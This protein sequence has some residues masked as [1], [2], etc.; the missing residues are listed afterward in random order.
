MFPWPKL[1]AGENLNTGPHLAPGCLSSGASLR[2]LESH[3]VAIKVSHFWNILSGSFINSLASGI[4]GGVK[5]LGLL[6]RFIPEVLH[7]KSPVWCC[8]CKWVRVKSS[9][10]WTLAIRK[11][12]NP[13][14]GFIYSYDCR[15]EDKRVR[16]SG[17]E[18]LY[19]FIYL[20]P[21]CDRILSRGRFSVGKRHQRISMRYRP[22]RLLVFD[23]LLLL[24]FAP[25]QTRRREWER[26]F[27]SLS[28]GVLTRSRRRSR[29]P[30]AARPGVT[31]DER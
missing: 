31:D 23:T 13:Q 5:R 22:P 21:R 4:C 16:A 8:K 10:V 14:R 27:L 28:V 11:E 17:S 30:D 15:C 29:G 12:K 6:L 25:S 1:W 7:L 3:I 18:R 26:L 24:L 20:F 9:S 19:L 2:C